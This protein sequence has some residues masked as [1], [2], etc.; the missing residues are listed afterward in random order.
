MAAENTSDHVRQLIRE[1]DPRAAAEWLTQAFRDKN[2][3]LFNIAVVQQANIKKLADQIAAGI[4]SNDEINR[5]QAKTNAALLHLSDEYARL[6]ESEALTTQPQSSKTWLW[7]GGAILG[8]LLLGWG[9]K[10]ALLAP[11]YPET[12]DLEVS[13]HEKT[14]EQWVIKEGTVNL[15]LGESEPEI[16]HPLDANGKAVFKD[17]SKK[18]RGDSLHLLYFP[19]KNRRFR[20]TEQ[21]AATLTGRNQLVRFSLEFIP[22]TTVFSLTLR[23]GKG[24]T[25]PNAQITVDGQWHTSSDANGYFQLPVPKPA[26]ATILLVIEKNGNRLFEQEVLLSSD[27]TTLPV[28]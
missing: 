5:E 17:L 3:Q 6:Y 28:E 23:D 11:S 7:A 14:G 12:F 20:I 13:L 15:R 24:K 4:L 27:H 9:L 22:D 21:S 25:I 16:P 10:S 8:L 18:F 1:N 19:V 26:G 2:P